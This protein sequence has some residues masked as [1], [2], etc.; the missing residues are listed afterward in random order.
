MLPIECNV[1]V[2]NDMNIKNGQ[3]ILSSFSVSILIC[4]F[5]NIRSAYYFD[6][7]PA[8]PAMPTMLTIP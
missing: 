7:V 8:M 4:K 6:P 2:F 3:T 1:N 5:L